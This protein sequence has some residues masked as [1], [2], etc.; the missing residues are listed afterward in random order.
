MPFEV[1]ASLPIVF[2]TAYFAVYKIAVVVKHDTVLIH[3][4][5]GGLGQALIELC[6][7]IGAEIFATVGNKEKKEFLMSHFGIPEDHIFFSR[8]DSFAKNVMRMTHGKGV[9]VIMNSLAGDMLRLSWECIAPFGRFIELGAR[10]YTINSRLEMAK[11]ARNVSFSAVNLVSL[12]RERPKSADAVWEAVMNL[13]RQKSIRPPSPIV[14]FGIS[15][16]E[17]AL[18]TMQTGKHMGKLVIVPR[19]GERVEVCN[20]HTIGLLSSDAAFIWME[21]YLYYLT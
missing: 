2:C 8:D 17:A 1:A 5:S 7:G 18:R 6:Q 14:P 12:I 20:V 11:F 3:A 16:V 13:F 9:N 19:P 15:E 4:A 21:I 10:D